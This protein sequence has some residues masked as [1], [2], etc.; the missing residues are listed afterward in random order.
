[1]NVL[2]NGR[3]WL[4]VATVLHCRVCLCFDCAVIYAG[5]GA[6]SC[7]HASVLG[8]NRTRPRSY[9]KSLF[10][11]ELKNDDRLISKG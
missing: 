4:A 8:N 7:Q 6:S 9:R 2:V 10:G 1:M 5:L 11:T 3:T